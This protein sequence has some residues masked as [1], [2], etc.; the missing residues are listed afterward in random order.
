[1]K[2]M[3]DCIGNVVPNPI[4]NETLES[5]HNWQWQELFEDLV[6]TNLTCCVKPETQEV[7]PK[8]HKFTCDEID[9][10]ASK[11]YALGREHA[12]EQLEDYKERLAQVRGKGI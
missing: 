4:L 12:Q 1:M 8:D 11:F 2:S 10:L 3:I 5:E 6:N 9:A 7:D